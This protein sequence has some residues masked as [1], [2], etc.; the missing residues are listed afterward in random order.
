MSLKESILTENLWKVI[1]RMSVP[2]IMGMLVISLNSFVDAVFAG[3]LIGADALAGVS[4]CIPLL[5]VNSAITGFISSGASNVVSRA[6]G[7][8]DEFVL[9]NIFTYVLIFTSIASIVLGIAGYSYAE[10]T[11]ILLGASDNV[12]KEATEYYKSMMAGCFTSIFGLA[13]SSLI[14]AQ[15]QMKYTMRITSI[16]VVTNIILNP[17]LIGYLNLGIKGSALATVM[18]MGLFSTLTVFHLLSKKTSV[19]INLHEFKFEWQVVSEIAT[20]GLSAL[21]MQLNGFV[22]QVFLFKTVTWYNSST[23]VAFFS[24]V[25]RI[26][27]FSVIPIFGMLQAMQPV[28]GINYGAKNYARST[29]ALQLFRIGCIGLMV[30]I[31]IPM[32]L[33]PESVLAILLPGIQFSTQDVFNFRLLMCILPVAPIASTS[34]VFLQATGKARTATYLALGRELLLFI[35]LILLLPYTV[36]KNGVYYGLFLENIVFMVIVFMVVRNETKNVSQCNG[37][38]TFKPLGLPLS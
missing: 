22:R 37:I 21:T 11:L 30:I 24:A 6:I 9:K 2:G 13:A 20:I 35:P 29:N 32:L 34:V 31:S 3:R 15:G 12:L 28:I 38:Q 25:F 7:N 27:S 26:F 14:R 33:F 16:A 19:R 4:L 36:G 1:F 17:L 10:Q 23:D 5:M 8:E 18:S